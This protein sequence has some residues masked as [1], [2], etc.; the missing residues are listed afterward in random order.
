MIRNDD[1]RTDQELV[2][3]TLKDRHAFVAIVERYQVVLQRY[4]ARLGCRD[5][6]DQEDVLQEV[7]LKV[8]I[9]LN[10]YDSD[11]KFSSWIY[12]ITHNETIS[13]FRK[14]SVQ[15]LPIIT[16]EELDRFQNITDDTDI[17]LAYSKEWDAKILR[18]VLAKLDEQYRDVLVLKFIEDKSYNE[19][20]DILKIPIGTV[21]TL[22]NRG[23]KQLKLILHKK[24]I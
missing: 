8:Y 9:N 21:G 19:I 5:Y 24:K 20:S 14:K 22:I 17:A 15:P 13:Y 10:E 4:I 3:L 6:H 16:G 23:K 12:R 7:F 18:E 2:A 11:L 1:V